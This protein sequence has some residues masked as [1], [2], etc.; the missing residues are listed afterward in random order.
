VS[1]DKKKPDEIESEEELEEAEE[2]E[3]ASP[4]D[5][6]DDE[7]LFDDEADDTDPDAENDPK[8][9]RPKKGKGKVAKK[10]KKPVKATKPAKKAAAP[11]KAKKQKEVEDDGIDAIVKG[12]NALGGE[13][14]ITELYKH[15]LAA[16]QAKF[17]GSS[18]GM[19]TVMHNY[20]S[21]SGAKLTRTSN[22]TWA[23][24]GKEGSRK[25]AEKKAAPAKAKNGKKKP[26]KPAKVPVKNI[27]K[28]TKGDKSRKKR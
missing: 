10:N 18:R 21:G 22:T 17:W 28:G 16:G 3:E 1:D 20:A 14:S 15:L 5:T 12:L 7:A 19:R 26:A 8:S 4:A 2:V 13:A 24:K 27:A 9:K 25:P 23:I 6:A 11:A